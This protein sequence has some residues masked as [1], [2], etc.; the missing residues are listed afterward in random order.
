MAGFAVVMPELNLNSGRFLKANWTVRDFNFSFGLC[1]KG[2]LH[3]VVLLGRRFGMIF[4][5][6]DM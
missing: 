6:L 1:R 3:F 5:T 4:L 2:G